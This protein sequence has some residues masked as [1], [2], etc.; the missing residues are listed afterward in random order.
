MKVDLANVSRWKHKWRLG[1]EEE[2]GGH[3]RSVVW[4]TPLATYGWEK[5]RTGYEK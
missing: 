5:G 4:D 1:E 2:E 3:N